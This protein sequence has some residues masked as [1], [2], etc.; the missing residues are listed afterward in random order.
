ML[1]FLTFIMSVDSLLYPLTGFVQLRSKLKKLD[2]LMPMNFQKTVDKLSDCFTDK[3]VSDVFNCQSP[4]AANE[5]I[6]KSLTANLSSAKNLLKICEQLE[7]I[8]TSDKLDMMIGDLKESCKFP[9]KQVDMWSLVYLSLKAILN[10]L[11]E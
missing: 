4:K 1:I 11:L 3:Q 5:M 7:M 2:N 9:D 8:S 6:L 10:H